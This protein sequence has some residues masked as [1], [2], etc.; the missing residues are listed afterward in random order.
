M[1]SLPPYSASSPFAICA[2]CSS[3]A[4]RSSAISRAITSGSG[5]FSDSDRLSSFIQKMSRL[6]LSR[7]ASSSYEKLRQRPSG[8]SSD[9]VSLR[10]CRLSAL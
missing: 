1:L 3:A 7:F 8:L 10:W 9:H 2:N 5:R 4:W 6:S